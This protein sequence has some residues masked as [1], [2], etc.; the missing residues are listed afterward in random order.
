MRLTSHQSK[1]ICHA[2]R[3]A[4]GEGTKVTLFGSRVNDEKRGGDI[5]LLVLP[6]KNDGL[7]ARKIHM[8]TLLEQGLG[9]RKVDIVI[10]HADDTRPIV[11]IARQTGVA[12]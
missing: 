11:R 12:L 6:A 5:D 8:L 2:A 3:E 10:E 9:E 4:F 1:L 7:I